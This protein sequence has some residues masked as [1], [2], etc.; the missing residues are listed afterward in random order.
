V[1]GRDHLTTWL[2]RGRR[3]TPVMVGAVG[4][5]VV[6]AAVALHIVSA[7]AAGCAG[8][9]TLRIAATPEIAP[10]IADAGARWEATK[11]KVGTDCVSVTVHAAASANV[12]SSLTALAG[13]AI[14]VGAAD[15]GPA[16]S[17]PADS[18]PA[19]SGP[20]ATG[21]SA[22]PTPTGDALAAV[23]VP[24]STAWLTR[25]AAVDRA[26]FDDSAQSIA[27]SPVVL[28]M[29]DPVARATGWP[30]ARLQ[31]AV[32]GSMLT[33]G[34]P[35]RFGIADP[36]RET[37]SLAAAMLLG[38]MLAVSDEDLPA[39]VKT[40]RSMA[41]TSSTA[42]LL[43]LVGPKVTAAPVSEQ[44]VLA[45]N[46]ANPGSGIEAV[47]VEPAAPAL[48]YPFA[49]RSSVPRPVAQAAKLFRGV[50]REQATTQRLAREGFRD[51][52]GAMGPGFPA[53]TAAPPIESIV[54]APLD[55]AA[56]LN[57][58]LGLWIA[59][60]I[61]SRTLALFDVTASMRTPM[62]TTHGVASRFTVMLE[63]ARSGLDMFAADSQVGMWGFGE[64]HLQGAP[65][66]ELTPRHKAVFEQAMAAAQ[67]AASDDSN[68]YDTLLAA[69]Q[70][71]RDGYD[72][73]RPNLI[74]VLTDGGDSDPGG[75][76]MERFTREL[77]RL[78]DP[79]RPIR[80][81]LIGIDVSTPAA[82]DLR[83]IAEVMGGGYFPLSSPEQIQ[84]IFLKALLRVG[85]N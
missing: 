23:W 76:R 6:I 62:R 15:A 70:A 18:R 30:G 28:A 79:T 41:K 59:A 83:A 77:Q 49:I 46:V 1:F 42:D 74:V 3:S 5:V 26:A 2:A 60:N 8:Q 17:G 72:P 19:G 67:P 47:P 58:A 25:V 66:A 85:Y 73:R 35:I 24:D 45:Y 29:P 78:A 34:G 38:E 82:A 54:G 20:V 32:L 9:I 65:I 13:K 21:A 52:G 27:S 36:R 68:L 71:M 55:D 14:D 81:I 75:L 10:I 22:A 11:P 64:G 61:A 57:R 56:R 44:A 39:L 12:A 33:H 80:V 43:R 31:V 40:F 84:S 48:D 16:G 69:Y 4:V 7:S 51:P 37:A 63:A 53:P 50:L